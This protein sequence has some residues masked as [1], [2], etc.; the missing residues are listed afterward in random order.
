MATINKTNHKTSPAPM[1]E[2]VYVLDATLQNG[3]KLP[4]WNKRAR[5][6]Q[7][8]D[9]SRSHSSTVALVRNLHTGYISTS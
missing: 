4:K 3:K 7:F 6:T 2:D 9:V 5:M 1:F 8:I